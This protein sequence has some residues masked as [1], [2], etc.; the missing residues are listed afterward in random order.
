[1]ISTGTTSFLFFASW[2]VSPCASFVSPNLSPNGV[3]HKE[4]IL[5][6]RHGSD[7]KNVQKGLL[8]SRDVSLSMAD[9]PIQ[10]V[11]A[12]TLLYGSAL[13]L[14]VRPEILEAIKKETAS[15]VKEGKNEETNLPQ[16]FEQVKNRVASM[17]DDD[18]EEST[19]PNPEPEPV[20]AQ[21]EPVKAQPET[22]VEEST[23]EEIAEIP[24]I[25]LSDAKKKVASTLSGEE[26]KSK[27]LE[28]NEDGV[29][30]KVEIT[31]SASMEEGEESDVPKKGGFFKL[32]VRIGKK[33]VMPWRKFSDIQ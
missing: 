21:P 23:V 32:L 10:D 6:P 29:V 13:V 26:E 12:V 20:K 2:L 8:W 15:A 33:V 7:K 25:D 28:E 14:T 22:T 31:E 19:V 27:R 24:T 4:E 1:M 11:V 18:T 30:D 5:N 3:R 9:L 17:K 16:F